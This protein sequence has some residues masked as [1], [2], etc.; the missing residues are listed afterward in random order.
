MS[1]IGLETLQVSIGFSSKAGQRPDNED[2]VGACL[3]TATQ[4]AQ[5]GVAAAVADGIGGASGGRE[6][7]ETA[8]RCFI[9]DYYDQ[10]QSWGVRRSASHVLQSVNSWL[11]AM[12]KQDPLLAGMGCAFTGLVLR[13]RTA[14]VLHVGDT[15]L[16]RLSGDRLIRLT[17]D[18]ALTQPGLS[19]VLYRAMGLEET[20]RLDYA[21]HPA[22]PH[23]RFLLCCDGVHGALSDQQIADILMKRSAPEDTAHEI[24]AEALA[25]GSNDNTTA[26]V[27]DIINLPPAD[28]TSIG[29][30]IAP[31]PIIDTPRVGE[32]IDGF[33]LK[34][35]LSEGRYSRLFIAVD[36]LAGG[37]V[38][39]KFPRP[40]VTTEAAY[41]AAFIREAWV[42][43]RV[44][45]PWIGSVI[46]LPT[47]RQSCLYT[48]MPF[49]EGET[50]EKR[51][52]RRPVLTLEEGRAIALKLGRAIAA[53]HRARMIHR[54]IKP[55]NI[56][57]GPDGLL[58]LL[59]LGVVR[60]PG[61]EEF[62]DQDIPGTPSYM[63]PE[64]FAG[65]TGNEATDQFALGVTLFRAFTGTYPYGEIEAFSRPRFGKP[66]GLLSNRPDLPAWLEA[67]LHR[68]ISVNPEAR[69]GDV[70]EFLL[71]L[72]NGPSKSGTG[73]HRRMPLY[74]RNPLMFWKVTSAFLFL[75]LLIALTRG[76]AH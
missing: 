56:M 22:S 58:K 31:L 57:L 12:G 49:Y 63:A 5:Q 65:E 54:D 76:Y 40:A 61:L 14:H 74:D 41:K 13:G 66:T 8:V 7:A 53:L 1:S 51:L 73:L 3:G 26:L 33:L 25:A 11:H 69:Y 32:R 17:Q 42:A 59:D 30:A 67:C 29:A 37:Q 68:A 18:H 36:E 9:D 62:P 10:P 45:S 23:D 71:D 24:V 20:V 2:F 72:E 35:V 52:R 21:T 43:A 15:R 34:S 50:L 44:R 16:Y 60:L 75:A 19:H 39:L 47:D 48:V 4:R 6:A 55:D 64:M 38:V 70:E 27:A 46:E 28:Q